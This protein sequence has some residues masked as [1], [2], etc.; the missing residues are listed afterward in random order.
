MSSVFL[1]FFTWRVVVIVIDFSCSQFDALPVRLTPETALGTLQ[2]YVSTGMSYHFKFQPRREL[3]YRQRL[4]PL[5]SISL[6]AAHS[7]SHTRTRVH[8]VYVRRSHK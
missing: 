7:S 3:I 1:K 2:K 8:V 5:P 4:L 6:T